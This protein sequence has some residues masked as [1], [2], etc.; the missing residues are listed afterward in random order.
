MPPTSGPQT[1]PPDAG[2]GKPPLSVRPALCS[3]ANCGQ[4][5]ANKWE[6]Q[7]TG[8]VCYCDPACLKNDDCCGNYAAVC[9]GEP[10]APGGA[11]VQARDLRYTSRYVRLRLQV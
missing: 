3:A 11:H 9:E 5:L 2:S 4:P 6:W 1:S 10:Q 8:Q 7:G